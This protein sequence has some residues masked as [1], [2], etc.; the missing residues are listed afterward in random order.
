MKNLRTRKG[1]TILE[2]L[3]VLIVVGILVAIAFP[4]FGTMLAKGRQTSV[5]SDVRNAAIE[6]AVAAE[7][8]AAADLATLLAGV[9]AK[10]ENTTLSVTGNAGAFTVSGV[11]NRD[12]EVTGSYTIG[13]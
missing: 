6:V 5:D 1:F 3:V 4:I 9:E 7:D 2:L 13:G 8:D 11:H 12:A 10:Y